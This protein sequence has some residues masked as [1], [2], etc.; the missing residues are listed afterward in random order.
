MDLL[1][2]SVSQGLLKACWFDT[3]SKP[4]CGVSPVPTLMVCKPSATFFGAS[5]G[6]EV[7]D[8]KIQQVYTI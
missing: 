6:N 3:V 5:I 8:L 2:T 7:E 1:K 4:Y